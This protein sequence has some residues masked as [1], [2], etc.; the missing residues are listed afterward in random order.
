V[1][2]IKAQLAALSYAAPDTSAQDLFKRATELQKHA[3]ELS[4]RLSSYA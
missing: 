3:N 1:R 2:E 4:Y